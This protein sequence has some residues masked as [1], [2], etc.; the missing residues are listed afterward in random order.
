MNMKKREIYDVSGD[1]V[2]RKNQSCPRCGDGIYMA[3]H[4]DRSSCGACGY[5]I[6]KKM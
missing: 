2:E 5:T 1:K 4:P 3:N 6:W